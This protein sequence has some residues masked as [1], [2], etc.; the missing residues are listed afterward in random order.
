[1]HPGSGSMEGSSCK[2]QNFHSISEV[3]EP[4]EGEEEDMPLGLLICS[5][6]V[7]SSLFSCVSVQAY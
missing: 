3:V 4:D 7:S 6:V 1:M 2:G 5:I